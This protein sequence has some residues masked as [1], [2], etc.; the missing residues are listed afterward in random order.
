M[1]LSDT[2]EMMTSEDFRERFR[3][4]YFQLSNRIE[5]LSKML[6]NYRAGTLNFTPKCS[7]KLLDCQLNSMIIY[8]THLEERARI[9][10]ISLEEPLNIDDEEIIDNVEIEEEQ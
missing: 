3:A 1:K 10:G 5:G 8:K 7:I 4:E 9:E 2:V 6:E